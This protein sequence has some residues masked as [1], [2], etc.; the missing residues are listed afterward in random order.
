MKKIIGNYSSRNHFYFKSGCNLFTLTYYL[1]D[2][3]LNCWISFFTGVSLFK[4][5]NVFD[6]WNTYLTEFLERYGGTKLERARDLFEQCLETCPEKFAKA[7]YILYAKLELEH[8]SAKRGK[9][10]L[11]DHRKSGCL[12]GFK[13]HLPNFW[14][15]FFSNFMHGIKSATLEIEILALFIPNFVVKYLYLKC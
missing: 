14:A 5:P 12:R 1:F 11:Q 7:I 15:Q 3:V 2:N 9:L 10:K 6:I 4:W 13:Y 8:G